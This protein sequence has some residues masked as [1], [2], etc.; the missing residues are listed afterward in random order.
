MDCRR[1]VV[2]LVNKHRIFLGLMSLLILV[3]DIPNGIGFILG[4][5]IVQ[6]LSVVREQYYKVLLEGSN[7][8]AASYVGYILFLFVGLWL[9]LGVAFFAPH[10]IGPFG[11]AGA[12][13][14]DRMVL[15]LKGLFNQERGVE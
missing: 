15:Y 2:C 5:I 1:S 7:F 3:I 8:K 14:L 4:S 10:I 6:G 11:Y 12:V 9:P 13:L